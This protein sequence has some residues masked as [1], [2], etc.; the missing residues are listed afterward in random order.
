MIITTGPCALLQ[1]AKRLHL[2]AS[3]HDHVELPLPGLQKDE[4]DGQNLKQDNEASH[5]IWGNSL[6]HPEKRTSYFSSSEFEGEFQIGVL[7]L[8]RNLWGRGPCPNDQTPIWYWAKWGDR[9]A[10]FRKLQSH[11]RTHWTESRGLRPGCRTF[12]AGN[13]RRSRR[14]GKKEHISILSF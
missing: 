13:Y 14:S 4:L 3:P 7:T 12:W 6:L 5:V 1:L 9:T 2:W 10:P 8:T 11:S